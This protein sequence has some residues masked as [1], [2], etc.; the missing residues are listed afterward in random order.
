MP[1]VKLQK[2][3][4][5]EKKH[6]RFDTSRDQF[7]LARARARAR[8]PGERR[9]AFLEKLSKV[10]AVHSYGKCLHNKDEP[11]L[12]KGENRGDAKR[13]LLGEYK[14]ALAVENAVVKDYVSEKVFDALLAGAG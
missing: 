5:C 14:F 4:G 12:Q 13:R 11:P 3:S 9:L 7:N 2:C 6:P 8:R 1:R 10:Y